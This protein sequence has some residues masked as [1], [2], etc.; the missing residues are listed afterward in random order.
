MTTS[1][2]HII[3]SVI[4][5]LETQLLPHLDP[6]ATPA[7]SVRACLSMLTNV[8]QRATL[9]AKFL[10]D[11]N[12]ALRT[13]LL[14]ALDG[15]VPFLPGAALG[16]EVK[17]ALTRYPDRKEFFDVADAATE[18]RAYQELLTQLIKQIGADKSGAE[19]KSALH[20]YLDGLKQRDFKLVEKALGRVP[21]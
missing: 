1:I 14:Q 13:L 12:Q 11:D 20:Q 8:E 17:A 2:Q 7:S 10:F 4:N 6:A 19:F 5:S 16:N 18:N 15:A 9:E 21:V 3:N